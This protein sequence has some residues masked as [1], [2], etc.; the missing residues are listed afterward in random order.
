MTIQE[1]SDSTPREAP[2][3]PLVSI[4]VPVCDEIESLPV[5][6]TRLKQVFDHRPERLEI[7]LVDDGSRDGSA[8]LMDRACVEDPR[9]K[10]LHLSRNFGHQAAITAGLDHARGDA[11]ILMDADLQ[12]PPEVLPRFIE[13][14]REGYQ[15]VYGIRRKRKEAAWKRL[16]YHLFYR[17]LVRVA[18]I[19]IPPDSGDFCL[20]DRCVV[21]EIVGLPEV[22]RF[23]RGLRSWA[24]WKQ[25][26]VPFER[27]RRFGG[28]PKYTLRGLIRL[29]AQGFV[30]FSVT[31]LRLAT[32]IGFTMAALSLAAAV[33]YLTL[34]ITG[35][36]DWPAG[37]ATIVLLICLLFGIQFILIGILGEYVGSIHAEVKRRPPYVVA[38]RTGPL[39]SRP[40]T[41]LDDPGDRD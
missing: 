39:L 6:L 29:A 12:D 38:R 9:I 35:V 17:L 27:D 19:D 13:R 40:S 36:G 28:E 11:V 5:L 8:E 24:G 22:S 15:V 4:A 26:G 1:Q 14:W 33:V 25:V 30:S 37:F 3:E 16:G 34:W 21:D 23:M 2:P 10:V 18:S 7:I 20:I 41:A 31:P 32:K